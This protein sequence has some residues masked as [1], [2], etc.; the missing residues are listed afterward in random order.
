MLGRFDKLIA[1]N[2]KISTNLERFMHIFEKDED[3]KKIP[4]TLPPLANE[5]NAHLGLKAITTRRVF[6]SS[7]E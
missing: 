1:V 3:R 4:I 7:P 6:K 2:Q 5:S